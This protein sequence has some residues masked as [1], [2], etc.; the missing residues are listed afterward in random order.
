MKYKSITNKTLKEYNSFMPDKSPVFLPHN[1]Y[2][3]AR[4]QLVI[5]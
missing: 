1:F 2:L 4:K 5:Y 3:L